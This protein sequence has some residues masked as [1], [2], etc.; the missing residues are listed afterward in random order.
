M[1]HAKKSSRPHRRPA[2][3]TPAGTE[4]RAGSTNRGPQEQPAK[5]ETLCPFEARRGSSDGTRGGAWKTG[6]PVAPGSSLKPRASPSTSD[7]LYQP[8]ALERCRLFLAEQ[9][10]SLGQR[11]VEQ[12]RAFAV[13]DRSDRLAQLGHKGV[14][15]IARAE[16]A[17]HLA[18]L[19]S[20]R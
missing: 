20:A 15:R 8:L 13:A 9:E 3:D 16:S 17:A 4:F 6:A 12:R 18:V 10:P 5:A 1:A 11:P 14:D 2:P 7:D 19:E